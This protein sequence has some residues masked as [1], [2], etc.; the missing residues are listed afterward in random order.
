MPGTETN[1]LALLVTWERD[2][3]KGTV[4]LYSAG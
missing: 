2:A 1:N 4:A 3:L